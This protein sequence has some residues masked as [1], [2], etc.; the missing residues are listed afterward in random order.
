MDENSLCLHKDACCTNKETISKY[1][2]NGSDRV[3][4]STS[5]AYAGVPPKV[6]LVCSFFCSHDKPLSKCACT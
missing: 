6:S 5:S 3:G 1:Q 4:I 2:K